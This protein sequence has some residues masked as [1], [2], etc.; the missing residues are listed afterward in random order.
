M[1]PTDG[2][3]PSP[4]L[5]E[6]VILAL[7]YEGKNC[8]PTKSRTW[9]LDLGNLHSIPLNYRDVFIVICSRDS[10]LSHHSSRHQPGHYRAALP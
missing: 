5:Y 3:Q 2:I 9:I 1:E 6:S 7:N 4:S 10:V 8:I